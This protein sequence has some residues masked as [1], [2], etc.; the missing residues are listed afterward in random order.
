MPLSQKPVKLF[1]H[2]E[3]LDLPDPRWLLDGLIPENG[4]VSIYGKSGDGKSFIALDWAL[5]IATGQAWLGRYPVTR[6]PVIYIAAEGGRGI[7]RRVEAWRQHYGFDSLPGI[8]FMLDP[9]YVRETGVIEEF[10]RVLEQKP[11]RPGLVVLDTLSRSFG[12]GE[13]NS[14]VDMGTFVEEVT[15]LCKGMDQQDPEPGNEWPLEMSVLVV[16][17]KN[18]TGQ[19]ER[20]S[21][22]FKAALDAAFEC[23][24]THDPDGK[25]TGVCLSTSKQKDDVPL[26]PI[27]MAPKELEAGSLIFELTEPPAKT[28][29]TTPTRKVLNVEGMMRVLGAA[30]DG[31]YTN[32]WRLACGGIPE[33]TFKRRRN[34]LLAQNEIFS[35]EDGKYRVYPAIEDLADEND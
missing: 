16:H 25:I 11:V 8:Y 29:G 34:R 33:T 18:A 19:R 26:P 4:F 31:L 12:G 2:T 28:R 22:V 15:K 9:L 13:E 17:H 24:A 21:T 35:G 23:D 10:A 20:G 7:K 14:S 3:L 6:A 1:N 27:Y 30:P 5:S 32:E